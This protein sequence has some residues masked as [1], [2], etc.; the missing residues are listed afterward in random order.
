M[1]KKKIIMLESAWNWL[2]FKKVWS[3]C[4]KD[5]AGTILEHLNYNT[6]VKN[7]MLM[8]VK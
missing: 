8:N 3:N 5:Y 4:K 6:L 1:N 2:F 7:M